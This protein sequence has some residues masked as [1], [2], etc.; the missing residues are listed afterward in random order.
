MVV[1]F[2]G[3]EIVASLAFFPTLS[4]APAGH[5]LP[6]ERGAAAVKAQ[7]RQEAHRPQSEQPR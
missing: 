6:V 5:T 1:G 2:V 4:A 3:R 7:S